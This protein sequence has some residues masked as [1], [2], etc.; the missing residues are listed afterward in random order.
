M[1]SLRFG[2]L[3][4][5]AVFLVGASSRPV[6]AQILEIYGTY[7]PIRVSNVVTGNTTGLNSS[8]ATGSFWANGGCIG[9]TFSPAGLGPLRLG[10]DVRGSKSPGTQGADTVLVGIKA[11]LKLPVIPIKPYI[12][13]SGGYVGARA[14]QTTAAAGI[15]G[16]AP[17]QSYWAYEILGGVDYHVF[18]NIDLRPIE[19]GG[20]QGFYKSGPNSNKP[21]ISILT[22][23]TGVV[24]Y[25]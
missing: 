5:A 7:Q 6:S 20:G 14:L 9:A 21:N 13:G 25:F 19:I 12:Q 22:L 11:A 4:A 23:S 1:P 18:P 15:N 8:Y 24:V 17:N 2:R 10:L 3:V 16:T